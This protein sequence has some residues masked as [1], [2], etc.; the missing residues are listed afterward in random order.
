MGLGRFVSLIIV[1]AS[2]SFAGSLA[3]ATGCSQA[4]KLRYSG[5]RVEY[6][7]G[8]SWVDTRHSTLGSCTGHPAG[9]MRY[10]SA[11]GVGSASYEFCDGTNWISM[12]GSF[13]SGGCSGSAGKLI[14]A[15]N[16]VQFC[17]GG[18][19]YDLGP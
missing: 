3:F 16:K 12:K 14:Y 5:N 8:S 6:C 13:V 2:V 19:W 17:D 11:G 18:S 10:N 7:N 1:M 9:K 4:G 15:S